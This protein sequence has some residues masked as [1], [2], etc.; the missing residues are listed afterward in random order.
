MAE[1]ETHKSLTD[2]MG[3]I[4]AHRYLMH[5]MFEVPSD[6]GTITVMPILLVFDIEEC[7]GVVYHDVR[8]PLCNY[9]MPMNDFKVLIGGAADRQEQTGNKL[10]EEMA[11]ESVPAA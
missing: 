7:L 10:P 4:N 3:E 6:I 11:A 1:Q 9:V 5:R 2:M 8:Q